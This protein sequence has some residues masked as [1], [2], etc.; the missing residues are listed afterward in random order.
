[1][2]SS[3]SSSSSSSNNVAVIAGT[4][5]NSVHSRIQ[6]TVSRSRLVQSEI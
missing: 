1:M 5:Q 6:F 3:S 2:N 4:K